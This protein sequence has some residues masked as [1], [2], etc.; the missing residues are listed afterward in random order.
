MALAEEPKLRAHVPETA[1]DFMLML[2]RYTN[3]IFALFNSQS[4]MYQ[5]MYDLVQALRNFSPQA[6]QALSQ[7]TKGSIL[8]TI[9]LQSRRYAA[10]GCPVDC[11][12]DW[13]KE[14]IELMLRRGPHTSARSK[15]AISALQEESYEKVRNGYAKIVR[16]GGIKHHRPTTLKIS[17]V[18]MI[19][20]K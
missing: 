1:E 4:P 13:T 7:Q 17:P 10:H 3:L 19:P 2:K 6:R 8:W 5:A 15:N 11:G 12:E 18:A 14:H 9:L 20:H 16:Y